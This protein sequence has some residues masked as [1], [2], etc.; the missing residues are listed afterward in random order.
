MGR[1]FKPRRLHILRISEVDREVLSR[2]AVRI[3]DLIEP[4]PRR[5][6]VGRV[7]REIALDRHIFGRRLRGGIEER[8]LG[9]AGE[10]GY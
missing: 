10:T 7:M 8:V 6:T 3:A 2:I 1:R 9:N 4:V 5:L